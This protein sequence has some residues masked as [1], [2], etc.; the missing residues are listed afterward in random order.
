M[1]NNFKLIPYLL[2]TVV[3]TLGLSLSLQSLLA[4]WSVPTGVPANNN[5]NPPLFNDSTDADPAHN[6]VVAHPLGI[7]GNLSVG[8]DILMNNTRVTGVAAPQGDSDGVSKEYVDNL[9]LSSGCSRYVIH[10]GGASA[11]CAAGETFLTAGCRSWQLSDFPVTVGV[12]ADRPVMTGR[13]SVQGGLPGYMCSFQTKEYFLGETWYGAYSGYAYV[14]CCAEENGA[15]LP[16]VYTCEGTIPFGSVECSGDSLGL[17]ISLP[18]QSVG[19]SSAGCTDARK[20]E[21]WT[22]PYECSGEDI[23]NAAMC[24]G[25]D[26]GLVANATKTLVDACSLPAGSSPKCEMYCASGYYRSGSDCFPFACGAS[27]TYQGK[28]YPTVQIGSQ[29]W[30]AKS[31]NVGTRIDAYAENFV[32]NQADNASIEKYCYND[33]EANCDTD[34]GLYTWDEA[35]QYVTA[36]GVQGICPTGWHI[37]TDGE[38]YTLESE[39]YLSASGDICESDRSSGEWQC[40]PAGTELKV[41]GSSG[42]DAVLSGF[43]LG[44]CASSADCS[45]SVRGSEAP[46]W[47]STAVDADNA[48]SRNLTGTLES[49]GRL[50]V[51]KQ[52]GLPVRCVK[53]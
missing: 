19:D 5:L 7:T 18:W 44:D 43:W 11:F 49:V 53:D 37:P 13:P 17:S 28:L 16:E 36:P 14:M 50:N 40:T 23:A 27:F 38:L 1:K 26:T 45:F 12:S 35:M 24:S 10:E 9:A 20:C 30:M 33:I 22:P 52:N 29:C 48:W 51:L 2:V 34:G 15:P 3:L 4:A 42:F 39:L 8:G 32:S 21:Y 25:D 47:T 41:G 46:F 6:P 31:L